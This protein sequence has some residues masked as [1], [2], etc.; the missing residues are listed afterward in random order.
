[1]FK[2][3]FKKKRAEKIARITHLRYWAP[4]RQWSIRVEIG[5]EWLQSP[6]NKEFAR[7]LLAQYAEKGISSKVEFDNQEFVLTLR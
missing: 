7:F 5:E 6:I 2:S 3:L 4:T 1:M